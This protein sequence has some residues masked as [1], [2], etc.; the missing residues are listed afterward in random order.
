MH[1]LGTFRLRKSSLSTPKNSIRVLLAL[2]LLALPRVSSTQEQQQAK[3]QP[4]PVALSE[5]IVNRLAPAYR[6]EA[7]SLVTAT[8]E[9]QE[10]WLKLSDEDLTAA[11]IGQL[12]RKPD[13]TEFLLKQLEK[14]PSPKLRGRIVSSLGGYWAA[15]PQSQTTLEKHASSDSDAGVALQALEALRSVRID[16]LR[17]LLQARMEAA[18][19]S[20]DSSALA[21][22][23]EEEDR[24]Y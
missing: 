1:Q 20:G 19:A 15:H 14:E 18:K 22:L 13:G 10:R 24:R 12:S 9:V 5:A 11:V 8:N 17:K 3:A 21:K 16:E 7:K 2:A 23:A 4:A 6:E